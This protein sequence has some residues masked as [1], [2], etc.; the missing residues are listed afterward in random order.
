MPNPKYT[1]QDAN[2]DTSDEEDE[3][4][5]YIPKLETFSLEPADFGLPTHPL[6]EVG[7]G[8]GPKDNA[9]VLM[10]I[11][12]NE[13]GNDHPI[14]HFVLLNTAALLVVSGITESDSS[15]FG[16]VIT[17]RGPAGG[18]W[19]EGL[20][21]ARYCLESGKALQAFQKF[22]DLTQDIPA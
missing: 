12:K 2:E 18:R 9:K 11:L 4:P 22:I 13:L 5:K 6:S 21:L 15:E 8:R 16:E 20:R 17:E 3:Q 1:R 14:L 19:K 7:G 10:S